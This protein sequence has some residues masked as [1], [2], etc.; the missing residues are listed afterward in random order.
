MPFYP[1]LSCRLDVD[2]DI[3]HAFRQGNVVQLTLAN[4][5]VGL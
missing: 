2:Q 3:L 5:E 4:R 1:F